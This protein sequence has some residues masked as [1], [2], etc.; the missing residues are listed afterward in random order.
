MAHTTTR[1]ADHKG[2]T[3]PR[4]QGDEYT[5]DADINITSYTT[6]GEVIPASELGLSR[7]TSAHI[8]RIGGGLIRHSINLVG[9]ADTKNNLYLEV[10]LEDNTT[11]I[12]AQLAGS[13][14]SL[15]GNPIT[16]RVNG[17]I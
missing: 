5:I 2:F 13:N 16:I 9:G 14:T 10:N 1:L 12:E 6:G 17:L 3:R 15:D 8:V 11:G 7:I 4:V